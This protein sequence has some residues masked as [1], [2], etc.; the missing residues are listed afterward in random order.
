[1][2]HTLSIMVENKFGEL[3]RIVG[4]F[5]ARGYNIESLTVAETLDPKISRMTLV[6]TG[7]D[8]TIK[9]I[10]R[11]L[12][13]QVRVLEAVD[14]TGF[15]HIEREMA[16]INVKAGAG[17]ERQEVL[18]LVNI[19]RAK[20]VDVSSDGII[21]EATGDWAKVSA[22]IE[23]LKPMGIREIVRTGTVAIARL[24]EA[25]TTVEELDEEELAV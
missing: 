21:V 6:T 12:D 22:L 4:L 20:V 24:S 9:Q 16:L 19:F 15:A 8:E 1:M 23:L 2:R 7:N 11:Q 13:K 10:T 14:M 18:S 25:S 3:S 5:S 17:V